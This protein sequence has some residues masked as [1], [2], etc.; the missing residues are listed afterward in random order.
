M[1]FNMVIPSTFNYLSIIVFPFQ[2]CLAECIFS[3]YSKI[4]ISGTKFLCS[5]LVAPVKNEANEVILFILN[6][7]DITDAP[8]KEMYRNSLRNSKK[9]LLL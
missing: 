9:Y 7:E 4:C 6:L 1:S 2:C 8:V 3:E 5:A